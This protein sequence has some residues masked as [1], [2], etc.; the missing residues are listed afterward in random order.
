MLLDASRGPPGVCPATRGEE[1]RGLSD[2]RAGKPGPG[3]RGQTAEKAQGSSEVKA[4]QGRWRLGGL[5]AVRGVT[6]LG[7]EVAAWWG[8]SGGDLVLL[9]CA[10]RCTVL[11]GGPPG[12]RFLGVGSGGLGGA[13][14]G[15]AGWRGLGQRRLG[16]APQ[17]GRGRTPAP[18]G[19]ELGDLPAPPSALRRQLWAR[20]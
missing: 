4:A 16:D 19:P 2:L 14:E 11:G 20:K 18:R 3:R 1:R 15:E 10:P 8:P 17:G 5:P 6:V 13:Q 9:S 12:S 7:A